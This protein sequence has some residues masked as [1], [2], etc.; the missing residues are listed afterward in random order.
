MVAAHIAFERQRDHSAVYLQS[1][2]YFAK[3]KDT[4]YAFNRN[5]RLLN[6]NGDLSNTSNKLTAAKAPRF[7]RQFFVAGTG[8]EFTAKDRGAPFSIC[9]KTD[10]IPH[11]FTAR[12]IRIY[13]DSLGL[14][15]LMRDSTFYDSVNHM[16]PS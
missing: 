6:Q 16:F 8:V 5:I 2:V 9:F 1:V 10:S 12:N 3:A 13:Q 15:K 14:M 4:V 11:G 7:Q